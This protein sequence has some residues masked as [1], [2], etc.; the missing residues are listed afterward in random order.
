MISKMISKP[1]FNREQRLREDHVRHR[2]Q[3]SF[4]AVVEQLGEAEVLGEPVRVGDQVIIPVV[5]VDVKL[6]TAPATRQDE[7]RPP[8]SKTKSL[9]VSFGEVRM[10]PAAERPGR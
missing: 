1:A 2:C 7:R 10:P 6:Q 9:T 3:R 8:D 5:R 4:D